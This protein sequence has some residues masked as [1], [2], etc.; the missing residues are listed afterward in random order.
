MKT[1]IY[2][3]LAALLSVV[4]LAS[5]SSHDDSSTK[6]ANPDH[7]SVTSDDQSKDNKDKDKQNSK[8][9]TNSKDQH[10]G[11]QDV[12]QDSHVESENNKENKKDARD[13]VANQLKMKDANIKQ[14]TKFPSDGDVTADISKNTSS[15]Y[16]I[17]YQSKSDKNIATFSGTLYTSA[18][19]AKNNL[20]GFIN[21][22]AVPENNATEIDL[23]HGIKGYGEGAAGHA[24]FSWEEGN[25]IMSISSLTK[26]QMNNPDIAR[27]MVDFLET[28]YLPAPKDTGIV[29]VDYPSGGNSVNVDIR[30]QEN[31][32]VYQLKTSKIPLDA[33]KMT[34]S[35]E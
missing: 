35:V 10:K 8:G 32:M 29:H 9:N 16:S 13:S 17:D 24:Y 7:N 4:L 11:D 25:W 6:P 18:K 28:H 31:N 2:Q 20:N 1:K 5:C 30:W 23:G 14:P 27:L 34:T 12:E 3:L 33:L 26:D 19:V 22:K 21:G 15:I